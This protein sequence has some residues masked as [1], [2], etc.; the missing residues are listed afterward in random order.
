MNDVQLPIEFLNVLHKY[1]KHL[2]SPF[3]LEIIS[4]LLLIRDN[5]QTQTACAKLALTLVNTA[6]FVLDNQ[7]K[8]SAHSIQADSNLEQMKFVGG[9]GVGGSFSPK[10]TLT[11]ALLEISLVILVRQVIDTNIIILSY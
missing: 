7:S 11:F 5:L 1:G 6:L 10:N 9:E 4:R 2:F 8:N 3:E